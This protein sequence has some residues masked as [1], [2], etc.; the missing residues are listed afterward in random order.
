MAMAM[1]V[2]A[3]AGFLPSLVNLS[4]RRAPLSLL[5]A[6]HGLTF[7]AWLIIFFVQARLIADH[8]I[9]IHK[10]TGMAALVVAGA[11]LPLGYAN[12]IAMVRRGFDLSGDL[13]AYKDPCSSGDSRAA[14]I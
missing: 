11:M 12:C 14:Y 10:R 2:L 7:F 4:G 13:Q 1:L 6:A 3:F 5:A 8:R 9:H